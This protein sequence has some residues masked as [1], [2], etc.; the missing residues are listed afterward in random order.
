MTALVLS[1]PNANRAIEELSCKRDMIYSSGARD[2]KIVLTLLK[3]VIIFYVRLTPIRF[4]GPS[5][6]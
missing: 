6:K 3:K 2:F 4:W 1:P 5:L